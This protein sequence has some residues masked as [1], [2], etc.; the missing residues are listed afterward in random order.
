MNQSVSILPKSQTTTGINTLDQEANRLKF[1]ERLNK[2]SLLSVTLCIKDY[3]EP[4]KYTYQF[5]SKNFK[6]N[7]TIH[8]Y[9]EAEVFKLIANYEH[10]SFTR[11]TVHIILDD[12]KQA[13]EAQQAIEDNAESTDEQKA[14]ANANKC[15]YK[16]MY[17]NIRDYE[18]RF[19]NYTNIQEIINIYKMLVSTNE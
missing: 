15:K 19:L 18:S 14:E 2:P 5:I 6:K 13:E 8:N 7:G 11:D 10:D 9:S 17:M 12:A 1:L 16:S 3:L 4:H